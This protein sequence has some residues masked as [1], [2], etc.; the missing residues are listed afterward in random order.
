MA[1]P[2]I[3]SRNIVTTPSATEKDYSDLEL[4]RF[5]V[6]A[7]PNGDKMVRAELRPYNWDTKEFAAS[8][9]SDNIILNIP[10]LADEMDR[11]TSI[12]AVVNSL[13]D[14]LNKLVIE[15]QLV[16]EIAALEEGQDPTGLQN[17]LNSV[18][19]QLGVS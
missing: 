2:R 3:T 18:R 9:A 11:C 1:M 14:L 19:N 10:S 6:K 17:Q 4:D 15:K 16:E 13:G 5:T 7:L 12:Q 8:G